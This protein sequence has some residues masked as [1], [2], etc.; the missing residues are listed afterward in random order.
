MAPESYLWSRARKHKD[1]G[2]GMNSTN[3]SGLHNNSYLS[4][5]LNMS[6]MPFAADWLPK[7]SA[8]GYRQSCSRHRMRLARDGM[9]RNWDV[10]IV[11]GGPAGLAAAIALQSRGLQVVVVDGR[12]PPIYQP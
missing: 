6:G 7:W 12:R 5:F 10:G 2:A 8:A 9:G 3:T 1:G 11:G 4:T